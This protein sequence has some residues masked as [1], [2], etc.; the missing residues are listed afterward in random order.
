[1]MTSIGKTRD[2]DLGSI[3]RDMERPEEKHGQAVQG[4]MSTTV[5]SVLPSH[6]LLPAPEQTVVKHV[7]ECCREFDTYLFHRRGV[8]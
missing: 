7:L 3:Q 4:L 6:R 5:K 2:G 1:M 8:I